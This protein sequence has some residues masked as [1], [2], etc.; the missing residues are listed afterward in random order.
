MH[1][2]DRLCRKLVCIFSLVVILSTSLLSFYAVYSMKEKIIAASYEKLHSDLTVTKTFFDKQLPGLWEV[3]DGK[4]LKGNAMVNDTLR[5]DAIKEMTGDNVTIFLGDT[6]IATT[7]TNPEG[8]RVI[9]TKA[10]EAVT[11]AV[12]N[13][14][15]IFVGKASVVGVDNQTIYEPIKDTTGKAIGMIF[16]GTPAAPY[17]AMI[18]DFTKKLLFFVIVAT[19]LAALGIYSLARKIAKPIESLAVAAQAISD[20]NLNVTIEDVKSRDEINVLVC[21]M[22]KMVNHLHSLV[23]QVSETAEHVASASEELTASAEQTALVTVQIAETITELAEGAHRQTHAV[24]SSALTIEKMSNHIQQ[25]ASSSE[26]VTQLADTTNESTKDGTQA[27]TTA[28][29]QMNTIESTVNNSATIISNLGERSQQ[30][31]KIVTTISDIAGQT[32]LLALNAAV[33]AA[34]AGEHGRGFAVV[35]VEIRK[36]A[37]QSLEAAGQITTLLDEIRS[38]TEAAVTSM[39]V[40]TQEVQKGSEVVLLA[41]KS[42]QKISQGIHSVSREVNEISTAIHQLALGSQQ[43]VTDICKIEAVSKAAAE[44]TETVSAATEEESATMEQIAASSE[45]LAKLAEELQHEIKKFTI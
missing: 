22:K 28:V 33:E 10:T 9:G 6:R 5:V 11:N 15:K 17:E 31:D 14:N 4:L 43:I 2:F 25:I 39:A 30:I 32:N 26:G 3:K 36:L 8:S 21:A 16:V 24:D 42:F 23:K 1:I 37:E 12:L 38:Q 20:G 44:Q 41:E 19:L 18:A 34:H 29:N 45:S 40:G 27:I 13:Q 35:A 7:V